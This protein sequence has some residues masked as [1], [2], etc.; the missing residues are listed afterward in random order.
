LRRRIKKYISEELFDIFNIAFMLLLCVAT[1][2]PYLNVLAHAFNKG[3]DTARGGLTIYPRVF[4]LENLR[5]VL[6]NDELKQAAIISAARTLTGTLLSILITALAAYALSKRDLPGR[7]AILVFL[8]IPMF[9]SGTAVSN[10]IVMHHLG[11]LNNFLVYIIPRAFNFFNMI[12]MRTY[13][14]TIPPSLEESAE[15]DGASGFLVFAR[16]I[17][18]LSLPM[19]AALSL[20]TAVGHWNDFFT[21]LLYIHDHR[22]NTLQYVLMKIVREHNMMSFINDL[23]IYQ[24]GRTGEMVPQMTP[25]SIRNAAIIVAVFPIIVVYP[26]L[27]KYFINGVIIGEVKE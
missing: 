13:F 15:I 9:I 2:Y 4:T 19:L 25:E 7:G 22:L 17:L 6:S 27:Q 12:I 10:F 14:C 1:L 5:T 26:F 18:P 23:R 24:T 3:A 8:T 20:F 16:I 21:N 11:L